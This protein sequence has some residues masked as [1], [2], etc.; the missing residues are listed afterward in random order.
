VQIGPRTLVVP[1]HAV[2]QVRHDVQPLAPIYKAAGLYTLHVR[3]PALSS[4]LPHPCH[5]QALDIPAGPAL[6]AALANLT[7][8]PPLAQ[9]KERALGF[10]AQLGQRL[11]LELPPPPQLLPP[12]QQVHGSNSIS[13]ASISQE[14]ASAGASVQVTAANAAKG[15]ASG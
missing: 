7:F 11:G 8:Q 4:L 6:D 12:G 15:Q 9:L 2:H 10:L 3:L 1:L 14:S 5:L 13:V